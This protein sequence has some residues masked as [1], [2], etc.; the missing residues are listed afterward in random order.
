M[1]DAQWTEVVAMLRRQGVVVEQLTQPWAAQSARFLVDSAV[2]AARPF[3][4]HRAMRVDGKW[5]AAAADSLPVG[6]YLV[7]TDQRL[8]MLA[9]YLLEPASEDGYTTWNSFDRAVRARASHP[10]RR[11]GGPAQRCPGAGAVTSAAVRMLERGDVAPD[12]TS[13][14]TTRGSR[15]ALSALRGQRWC[16]TSTRR[17][18][19][20]TAPTRRAASAM[21]GGSSAG[22]APRSSASRGTT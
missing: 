16:S 2:V 11:S 15:V 6:S 10:V 22:E 8:G 20:P 7:P 5:V 19:P 17:T 13:C 1:L 3:E 18:T 12:F 4:G 21:P 9:A 14:R